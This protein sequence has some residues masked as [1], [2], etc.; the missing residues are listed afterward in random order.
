[1]LDLGR[2]LV[3]KDDEGTDIEPSK[4]KF[5]FHTPPFLT[6]SISSQTKSCLCNK[7]LRVFIFY[8]PSAGQCRH[9]CGGM[10]RFPFSKRV[11]KQAEPVYLGSSR[12]T[13]TFA[14]YEVSSASLACKYKQMSVRL[15]RWAQNLVVYFS[16]LHSDLQH[17]EF[18]DWVQFRHLPKLNVTHAKSQRRSHKE[19]VTYSIWGFIFEEYVCIKRDSSATGTCSFLASES[20]SKG[21]FSS[22]AY[23]GADQSWHASWL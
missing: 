16:K 22:T 2:Y 13:H 8:Q 5:G 7:S 19:E 6:V 1:M 23:E 15:K 9:A 12:A 14:M 10:G 18:L 4:T 21:D 11:L 17:K 20:F 3:A